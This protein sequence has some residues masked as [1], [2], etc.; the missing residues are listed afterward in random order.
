MFIQF[1]KLKM[2]KQSQCLSKKNGHKE[3]QRSGFTQKGEWTG[4]KN[5]LV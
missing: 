4:S 3:I 1:S 5:A 2:N